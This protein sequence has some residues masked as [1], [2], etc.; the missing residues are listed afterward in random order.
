VMGSLAWLCACAVGP[1]LTGPSWPVSFFS[2]SV[3]LCKVPES[4]VPDAV[5]VLAL[6]SKVVLPDDKVDWATEVGPPLAGSS[7]WVITCR[8]QS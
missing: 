5:F 8:C 1:P 3:I 2:A 6:A 4:R 7:D